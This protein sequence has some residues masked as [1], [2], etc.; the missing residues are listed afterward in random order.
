MIL[1]DVQCYYDAYTRSK[2]PPADYN[3]RNLGNSF[4]N[5][6]ND[7]AAVIAVHERLT[8]GVYRDHDHHA[9]SVDLMLLIRLESVQTTCCH[10][11]LELMLWHHSD[12]ALY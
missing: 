5:M 11:A 10:G 1:Y 7:S 8:Y 3:I 4:R 2:H 9:Q 12:C 6:I